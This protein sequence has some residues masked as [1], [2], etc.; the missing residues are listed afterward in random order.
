MST[1]HLQASFQNIANSFNPQAQAAQDHNK[2]TCMFD[3]VHL[4]HLLSQICNQEGEV[5][6]LRLRYSICN[7]IWTRRV[8]EQTMWIVICICIC[9]WA[10]EGL[11]SQ[12]L[13]LG[14]IHHHSRTCQPLC[15]ST[16]HPIHPL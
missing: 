11:I 10:D 15:Y 3:T 9:S 12:I 6:W 16:K 7:G 2:K 5:D 8:A 14:P 13:D 1:A 4:Q